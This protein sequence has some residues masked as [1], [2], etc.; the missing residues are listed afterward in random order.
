MI[1]G[2]PVGLFSSD[3]MFQDRH[4]QREEPAIVP[5]AMDTSVLD[6]LCYGNDILGCEIDCTRK[7]RAGHLDLKHTISWGVKTQPMA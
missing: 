3:L 1:R 6:P 4:V 5:R 2:I 7:A